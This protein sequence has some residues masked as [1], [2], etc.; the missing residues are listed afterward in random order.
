LSVEKTDDIGITFHW[1]L[2]SSG[3]NGCLRRSFAKAGGS[4]AKW[5]SGQRLLKKKA[6]GAKV[7]TS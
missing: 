3:V 6:G 2:E 1:S 4:P 5:I 7:P